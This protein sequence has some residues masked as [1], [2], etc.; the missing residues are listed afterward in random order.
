MFQIRQDI[1]NAFVFVSAV[2]V[3]AGYVQTLAPYSGLVKWNGRARDDT[4]LGF[5]DTWQVWV[6]LP[7]DVFT[8]EQWIA[9]HL[10]ELI[11]AVSTELLVTN[12]TLAELVLG[13]STTNGLIIEGA[14]GV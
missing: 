12:C 7:Q 1:A 3:S 6:A 14:R 11:E 10:D 13:A 4:G 5:I 9:D 2:T 8:A